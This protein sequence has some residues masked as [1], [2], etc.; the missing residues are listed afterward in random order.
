MKPMKQDAA[1]YERQPL[2]KAAVQLWKADPVLSRHG[3]FA[4]CKHRLMDLL[5]VPRE[6]YSKWNM[7]LEHIYALRRSSGWT[8]L[9][10]YTQVVKPWRDKGIPYPSG[11]YGKTPSPETPTGKN[12]KSS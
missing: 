7:P 9:E 2:V 3:G 8:K 4:S 10:A 12:A 6:K 1:E 5:G 11:Y